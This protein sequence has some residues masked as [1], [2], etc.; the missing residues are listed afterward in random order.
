MP[1]YSYKN[2][3]NGEIFD[4][5]RDFKDYNSNY[6]LEDGTVCERVF[7]PPKNTVRIVDKNAEVFEKDPEYVRKMKPKYVRYKDGHRE[8]Y[9][10]TKHR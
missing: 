1:I 8:K 9:D 10:P 6:I 5:I 4:V 7:N 3:K 2:P